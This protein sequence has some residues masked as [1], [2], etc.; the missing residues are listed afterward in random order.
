MRTTRPAKGNDRDDMEDDVRDGKVQYIFL[1]TGVKFSE[2]SA[3]IPKLV[4]IFFVGEGVALGT[5]RADIVRHS[6]E[7]GDLIGY[8]VFINATKEE[9][10]SESAILYRLRM[11][12]QGGDN[13]FA[14]RVEPKDDRVHSFTPN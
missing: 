13:P 12:E 3:V 1:K 8:N 6:Q 11:L 7:L 4:F 5:K 14:S 10:I 9:E 2:G